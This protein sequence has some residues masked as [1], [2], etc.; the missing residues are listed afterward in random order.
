LRQRPRAIIVGEVRGKEAYSL[1][2]AM[3]TGHLSYSTIHAS[4]MHSLIQRL[5]SPPISLPRALLTSLDMVIFMNNLT[6]KGN[7]VRRVTNVTEIIKLDPETNRLVTITPFYWMSEIDDR[8]E[9]TKGS[10]LINKIK[11]ENMWSDER[12]QKELKN[13][14][15]VLQWMQ[16]NKQRSYIQ[17][18][19]VISDYY[20]APVEVLNN[21]E[22]SE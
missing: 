20:N 2:Q 6:V 12:L 13:R 1:F 3:T 15:K 7:P 5:E 21:I 19:R 22:A 17:V 18:G 11:L 16:K 14:I 9:D 10:R 4:D 8:F